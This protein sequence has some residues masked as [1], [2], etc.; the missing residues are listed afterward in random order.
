MT[1]AE[2]DNFLA[3]LAAQAGGD[4]EYRLSH[5]LVVVPEQATP[6]QIDAR[7][8]RAEEALKQIRDGTDFAQ[9]AA[10]FSD[11]PDALQGGSLGWRAAGAAAD[12]V[13]RAGA[14]S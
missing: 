1:D 4:V 13:R 11:A 2:V 7:R 9:V 5:V 3:T 8:R 14:R 6:D 10:G 12:G